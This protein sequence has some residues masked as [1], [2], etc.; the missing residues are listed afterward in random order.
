MYQRKNLHAH[1]TSLCG[2][3]KAR[4]CFIQAQRNMLVKSS[5]RFIAQVICSGI[6]TRTHFRFIAHFSSQNEEF[7]VQRYHKR[8]ISSLP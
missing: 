2:L 7:P 5:I 8:V 6:E 1:S 3:R 4:N